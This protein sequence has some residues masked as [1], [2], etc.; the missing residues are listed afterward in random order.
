MQPQQ[1]WQGGFVGG[2]GAVSETCSA[3]G[4][5]DGSGTRQPVTE[6]VPYSEGTVT[7]SLCCRGSAPGAA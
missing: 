2:R 1:R 5:P 4:I 7:G 6:N 3:A